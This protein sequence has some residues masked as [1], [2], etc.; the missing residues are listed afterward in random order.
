MAL[1]ISD[2]NYITKALITQYLTGASDTS[3]V[4]SWSQGAA[5]LVQGLMG[6]LLAGKDQADQ[7]AAMQWN[8]LAADASAPTADASSTPSPAS[9]PPM[10]NGVARA[11]MPTGSYG[12]NMAGD[13]PLPPSS[14]VAKLS[15]QMR[16]NFPALRTAAAQQGVYFDAPEAGSIGN[17]RTPGQQQALY[18]QGRTA[19]G[20]VV[21]GT[22]NSNHLTGNALDVVPRGGSTPDQIGKMV[23]ALTQ[24]DP[25]F[26]GMRSGATFSNLNDPL[27]VEQ[28]VK[29]AGYQQQPSPQIATQLAGP[30]PTPDTA[31]PPGAQPAQQVAAQPPPVPQPQQAVTPSVL[32]RMEKGVDATLK[33]PNTP[34][35]V[36]QQAYQYKQWIIQ[37]RLEQSLKYGPEA[38]AGEAAKTTAVEGA[39][40]RVEYAPENVAGA[41]TK[42]G[43]IEAAKVPSQVEVKGSPNFEDKIKLQQQNEAKT[44]LSNT[45]GRMA[46]NIIQLDKIGG[47]VNTDKGVM[48]NLNATAQELTQKGR[49]AVGTKDA[50]LRAQIEQDQPALINAIRQA[51]NMGARGLDSNVELSFYMKQTGSGDINTRLAALDKLDKAY[52]LGIGIKGK[53]PDDVYNKITHSQAQLG[54]QFNKSQKSGGGEDPLGIR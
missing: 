21:T 4:K 34:L 32:D 30:A 11:L 54:E 25:R 37:H 5:R 38:I 45:V 20:P 26:A 47:L 12:A 19:P 35:P 29:T 31:L 27:H 52:G 18:A 41:A 39:K 24:N 7:R 9:A 33:N 22:L 16:D 46:D 40:K 44:N 14:P 2:P 53:V 49:M 13:V 28:N 17:V 51:T 48:S 1:N 43:A 15:P 10:G 6:G 36:M 3:P 8:P 23:T 42:E 50:S